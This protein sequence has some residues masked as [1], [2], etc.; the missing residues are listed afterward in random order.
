MKATWN[1]PYEK[2][3]PPTVAPTPGNITVYAVHAD[4][5]MSDDLD[6]FLSQAEE[7]AHCSELIRKDGNHAERALLAGGNFT[8]AWCL[9]Q[10]RQ[11]DH[12]NWFYRFTATLP[13]PTP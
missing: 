1:N 10:E 9:F 7:I 2:S 4:T 11:S 12:N 5:E 13:L 6:L 3:T 8:V